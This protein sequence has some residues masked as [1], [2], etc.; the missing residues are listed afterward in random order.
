MEAE[1]SELD[2][3]IVRA[4]QG[5]FPLVKEPYQEIAADLGITE[6]EL[7]ERL[8]EFKA[9]R[10]IRKLGAVLKHREV[11]FSSNVLC[12]WVVPPQKLDEIAQNMCRHMAVTHCYDRNTT[13]DWPYNLYTMIHGKSRA[14]CEEFA[15]ELAREN[16]LTDR[17]MLFTIKE[18]KKTSMKY[19]CE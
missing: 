12:V 9:S 18:W 17:K 19:F 7:L 2:K 10:K 14:E 6:D 15:A 8:T 1:L 16:N 3:K 11:G 5:D 13:P 4:M